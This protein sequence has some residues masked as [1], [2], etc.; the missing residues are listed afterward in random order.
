M[1]DALREER[2]K[3]P[4]GDSASSLAGRAGRA[5]RQGMVRGRHRPDGKG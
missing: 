5:G 1:R 3:P 2:I 4:G